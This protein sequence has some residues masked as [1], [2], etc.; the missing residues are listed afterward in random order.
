MALTLTLPRRGAA[1]RTV[2]ALHCSGAGGRA[3]DGYRALLGADTE[4]IAP[5]LLGSGAQAAWPLGRPVTVDA[6]VERIAPLLAR[7]PEGVH[8]IGHSYGGALALQA[9]LRWPQRVRSV[10]L[11]EPVRFRLLDGQSPAWNEI[12]GV[13]QRIGALALSEQFDAAA[14]LFVDY[15]SGVGTWAALPPARRGPVAARMP[16]V[17][18]EFE[19]LFNDAVPPA[20]YGALTMPMTVLAGDGSPRPALQVAQRLVQVC[21]QA[22]LVR[23]PG[24]GHMGALEDPA[25]VLRQ[26]PEAGAALA[27]AA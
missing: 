21:G 23:V 4:L 7:A 19:A 9:A 25:A 14:E 18:A 8:L 22:R 11:Y 10:T 13:G 6:E 24:R 12:V 27:E 26:L 17:H 1:R 16:K 20:A 2:I 15:W 5:D 3:F